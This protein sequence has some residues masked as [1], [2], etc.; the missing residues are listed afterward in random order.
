[1]G[2]AVG[3][4]GSGTFITPHQIRM[5]ELYLHRWYEEFDVFHHG[6]CVVSD[7][8]IGCIA[9]GIGYHVIVHPPTN[10]KKRAYHQPQNGE[11]LNPKPYLERN[12]DIATAADVLLATP[13]G[14]ETIRSGTW[15][16]IRAAQS[17]SVPPRI[18]IIMPRP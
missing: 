6:D 8:T 16:T 15:S 3:F 18:A 10:P 11:I 5:A 17:L 13:E 14:P 12:R 7:I 9:E 1:M 4:T 2:K